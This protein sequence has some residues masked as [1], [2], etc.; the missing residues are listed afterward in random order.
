MEKAY[1]NLL[2]H[3]IDNGYLISV[4]YTGITMCHSTSNKDEII[5]SV[6]DICHLNIHRKND[7]H[8]LELTAVVFIKPNS[9]T[10][11]TVTDWWCKNDFIDKW[12][13]SYLKSIT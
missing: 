6:R 9:K 3:A 2:R 8:G 10:L 7:D 11:S 12:Y 4:E 1:I 13:L 5:D